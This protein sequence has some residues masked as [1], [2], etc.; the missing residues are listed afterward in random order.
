MYVSVCLC[1]FE[2]T[3]KHIGWSVVLPKAHPDI[4]T[5]PAY[6]EIHPEAAAPFKQ[7]V[8]WERPESNLNLWIHDLAFMKRLLS[9]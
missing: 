6:P 3:E 9:P 7:N 8:P 1:V 5:A 4:I 2:M